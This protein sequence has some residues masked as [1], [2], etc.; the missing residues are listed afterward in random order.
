MH[1][2]QCDLCIIWYEC[3]TEK[4]LSEKINKTTVNHERFCPHIKEWVQP[5][6]PSC[7]DFTLAPYFWCPGSVRGKDADPH[8][9][10]PEGCYAKACDCKFGEM[11]ESIMEEETESH[12]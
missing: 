2:A 4:R 1:N 5:N 6:K 9:Q 3:P 8:W 12:E 10:R 7:D 11:I